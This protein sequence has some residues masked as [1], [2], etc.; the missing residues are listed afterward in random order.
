MIDPRHLHVAAIEP[1][2][3]LLGPTYR[4]ASAT[5]MLTAIALQESGLRHRYQ[6][7]G[8]A[9][10]LWQFEPIGCQ[11]VLSHPASKEAARRVCRSLMIAADVD[12][13]Y[14]ALPYADVLAAVFARLALWRLPQPLP[15][16]DANP[17][18]WWDQYIECWR[19]GKPHRSRWDENLAIALS[20]YAT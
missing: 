20:A 18:Q 10:G 7:G 2:Y 5:V 8:P 11:G 13:V 19:P 6:I 17:D 16:L 15:A 12:K 4:S 3:A 14:Q 1:A 9:Q